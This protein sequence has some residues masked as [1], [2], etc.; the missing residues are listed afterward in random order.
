MSARPTSRSSPSRARRSLLSLARR[1]LGDGVLPRERERL[2]ERLFVGGVE[3]HQR[4][5]LLAPR[6]LYGG[7]RAGMLAHERLLL[8]RREHDHAVLLVGIREVRKD[9]AAD[10]KIGMT[11]MPDLDGVLQ[12]ERDPA[13]S[14]LGH[15]TSRPV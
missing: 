12:A 8:F 1:A 11:V 6:P 4:A 7:E 13:E 5:P 3:A 9:S 15:A 2:A 10:A 14:C